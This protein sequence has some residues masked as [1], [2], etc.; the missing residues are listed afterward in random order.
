[1]ALPTLLNLDDPTFAF[2][3]AMAHRLYLGL[4]SPLPRFS[5]V[6]YFIDP[7]TA[8]RPSDSWHLNH[9]QA[10]NDADNVIPG[11][12]L[13]PPIQGFSPNMKDENLA[14]AWNRSWWTFSNHHQHYVESD[15]MLPQPQTPP[16]PPAPVWTYPFW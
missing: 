6:P 10:H 7:F 13:G 14:D 15:A 1:M 16:P 9:Q 5:V 4:M 11:S 8:Q 3:H 12:Y 2:E